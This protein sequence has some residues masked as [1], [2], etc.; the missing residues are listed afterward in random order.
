MKELMLV[1]VVCLV[2]V[3]SVEAGSTAKQTKC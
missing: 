2:A 3:V 1:S